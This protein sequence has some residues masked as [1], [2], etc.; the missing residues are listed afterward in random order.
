MA[1]T[2]TNF[3]ENQ[4]L[5]PDISEHY[6]DPVDPLHLGLDDKVFVSTAKKLIDDS[7]K[8]F[9]KKNLYERRKKNETYYFG[10]QIEELEKKNYFRDNEARYMDN[11]VWEAEASIKPIALSR[12]PDLIIKNAKDTPESKKL[13]EDLTK[14][15][16]SQLR[17]RENR[18]ALGMAYKHRPVYFTGIIKYYWDPKKNKFGDYIFQAVHPNTVDVDQT[19]TTNDTEDMNWIAHH[20]DM[21]A[22]EILMKF[23][24]KKEDFRKSANWTE[25]D[26]TDEKKLLTPI[27]ISE[28]W[29]T[30]YEKKGEEWERI[31]GVAWVWLEKG[32]LLKKM[33]NPNWDWSGEEQTFKYDE[34]TN[35]FRTPN[36]MEMRNQLLTGTPMRGMMT[37]KIY[38]NYFDAPQ[39]P[40]IFL[41]YDQFGMQAYDE[42]SRIEQILYLQDNV[43][44]RGKQITDMADHARGK[45]VFSTESGLTSTDI[46]G[47]DMMDPDQDI[48][49]DG[50]I[51]KVWSLIPGIQPTPAL[52][53]DQ[54]LNRERV[55]AK[56][57]AH[58]TTRG[59]REAS[60]TATGRQILREADFSKQDDEV[61]DTINYAAEKMAKAALQMIK[62]RYTEDHLVRLLGQDGRVVFMNINRDQ[63]EDGM[64]VEV[65]ASAVDKLRRKSEAYEL[66]GMQ[67]ID[68]VN[69]FKDTETPEPEK[70]AEMLMVFTLAPDLYLQ[71]FIKGQDTAGMIQQ[72]NGGQPP[73]PQQQGEM[74]QNM[75]NQA[76]N[77][78]LQR[79]RG[80]VGT[81]TN[82]EQL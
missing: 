48:L 58:A 36:E 69:F 47:I 35:E 38:Y 54:Q 8:F 57:G 24:D 45:N 2:Q 72:L 25:K 60:E 21:T 41:G 62:L 16:N 75:Q 9:K 81:P 42:T 65:S 31:E 12:I 14:I 56:A 73:N 26:L 55:F 63:V 17:K 82:T 1:D 61:E 74:N 13:G 28:I 19:A 43:N 20:Y 64:E 7:R 44:K 33:K 5:Q 29:F 51:A 77:K 40:F 71:K 32:L 34:E 78:P 53:E 50:E 67:M 52:F 68:P 11:I 49:I 10:R 15:I 46:E 27:R 80:G 66:A 79:A 70:R 4:E 76:Q 3:A 59:E 30:W 22:K 18:R 37:Q 6:Q 39:K 23:P